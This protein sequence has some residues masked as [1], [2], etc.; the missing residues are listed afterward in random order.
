MG[1]VIRTIPRLQQ[2]ARIVRILRHLAHIGGGVD[3]RMALEVELRRAPAVEHV[4]LRGV[5]DAEQRLLQRHRVVDAKGAHLR[6]GDR[7]FEDV[8]G[9]R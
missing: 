8:M 2:I 5:A 3:H 9:H 7:H 4:D 6:L 1:G